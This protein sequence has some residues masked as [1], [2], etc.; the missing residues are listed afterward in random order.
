VPAL[1]VMPL[2]TNFRHWQ[3]QSDSS[4]WVYLVKRRR[5]L[6]IGLTK[7]IGDRVIDV[8]RRKGWRLIDQIGPFPYPVARQL[9]SGILR[10]LDAMGIP[11]GAA[12]I[13]EKFDG[14]TEC[15]LEADFPITKI[16]NALAQ[17]SIQSIEVGALAVSW[18]CE[19]NN[20]V[21]LFLHEQEAKDEIHK[22]L[23]DLEG[24]TANFLFR[25]NWIAMFGGKN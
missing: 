11:R 18:P 6:K 22:A 7:S 25:N 10:H 3:E 24:E 15:W 20:Q 4:G 16:Q 17:T 2:T 8:H 14:Y 13:E 21:T 23:A 9:E 19:M 5:E 1:Q 12:A